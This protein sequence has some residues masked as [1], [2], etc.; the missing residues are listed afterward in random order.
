MQILR[1]REAT[2]VSAAAV[3]VCGVRCLVGWFH[4]AFF[5][6]FLFCWV[7]FRNALSVKKKM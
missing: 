2:F 6:E 3:F 4:L 5:V 7:L 1:A